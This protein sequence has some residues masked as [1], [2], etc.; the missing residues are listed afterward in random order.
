M[1]C[2]SNWQSVCI[3][4]V[5]DNFLLSQH[6]HLLS[7]YT[8]VAL[9]CHNTT[10]TVTMQTLFSLLSIKRLTLQ[11]KAKIKLDF[12]APSPGHYNYVESETYKQV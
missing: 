8:I 12:V 6:K 3:V 10:F 9:Y 5:K 2:D 1:Y 7:P 11:Q 4:I